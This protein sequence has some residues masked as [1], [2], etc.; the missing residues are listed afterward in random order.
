MYPFLGL[1]RSVRFSLRKLPGRHFASTYGRP[2]AIEGDTE[3]PVTF[4]RLNGP[5]GY[6]STQPERE[7]RGQRLSKHTICRQRSTCPRKLRGASGRVSATESGQREQGDGRR[8]LF[9]R[10]RR[11]KMLAARCPQFEAAAVAQTGRDNDERRHHLHTQTRI[12]WHRQ[13]K[14][15]ASYERRSTHGPERQMEYTLS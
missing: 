1:V 4:S 5:R 12:F 10:V 2:L 11:G 7:S 13:M 9:W 6:H 14:I 3:G 8:H 15:E